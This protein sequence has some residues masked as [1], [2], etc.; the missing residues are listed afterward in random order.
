ML[1]HITPSVLVAMM[2]MYYWQQTLPDEWVGWWVCG[3][4]H[5]WV[6]RC[7]L[8]VRV[9]SCVCIC[10]CACVGGRGCADAVCMCV[11]QCAAFTVCLI[12][13]VV[14]L[15]GSSAKLATFLDRKKCLLA[16]AK[17]RLLNLVA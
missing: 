16:L 4:L 13:G 10:V 17:F 7:I 12:D 11:C 2:L 14:V 1:I 9:F 6:R 15:V 3:W 5:G 8:P